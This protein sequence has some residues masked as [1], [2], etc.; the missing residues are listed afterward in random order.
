M[1]RRAWDY[2]PPFV[3]ET[4]PRPGTDVATKLLQASV[5]MKDWEFFEQVGENAGRG[6]ELE[7]F[8]WIK[9]EI[10]NGL[11]FAEVQKP[12][13]SPGSVGGMQVSDLVYRLLQTVP[14]L[15]TVSGMLAALEA[16]TQVETDDIR[17]WERTALEKVLDTTES[18]TVGYADGEAIVRYC[19][20]YRDVEYI[21]T[22]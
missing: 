3:Y 14:S 21:Q 2:K 16:V 9:G 4:R 19:S 13:S 10:T 12:Y 1:C 7:F 22:R 5:R 11:P 6:I 8:Q 17:E 15:A 18:K 20:L